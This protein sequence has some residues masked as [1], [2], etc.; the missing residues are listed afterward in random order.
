M[1]EQKVSAIFQVRMGSI[2]LPGKVLMDIEGKPLLQHVVDRVRRSRYINEIILATTTDGRDIS[3]IEFA[4]K[5][6]LKYFAGNEDDVLD[7]FY[8]CARKFAADIIVRITPDD[9]FK[10]PEIIDAAIETFIKNRDILDYVT[11]TL[12]PSYPIGL[13]IEVFSFQSLEKAW[14][15]AEKPS[16]R[17]HVTPYI[18]NH[19]E[20]FRI[21]NFN[22]KDDISHFRWT[23]DTEAD[24]LFAREIY[25]RLY[26]EKP[27]FLMDDILD[28]VKR[29]PDLLKI[30]RCDEKYPG[31]LKSLEKDKQPKGD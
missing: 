11:N 1:Q 7:R 25:R 28:V 31:Y 3:I 15:E 22:Y 20:L 23:L 8:Q 30:N 21:R 13:D 14:R 9:P 29:E 19:P 24:L 6:S 16:E 18:W 27:G 10:D 2:R 12:P 5:Q 26:K 4:R 17:E